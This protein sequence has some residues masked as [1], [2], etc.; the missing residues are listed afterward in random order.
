MPVEIVPILKIMA[1][2]AEGAVGA[3][4]TSSSCCVPDHLSVHTPYILDLSTCYGLI[5]IHT[6]TPTL[7]FP[8]DNSNHHTTHTHRLNNNINKPT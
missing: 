4:L 6:A 7:V 3:L 1:L 2:P 8:K 5:V